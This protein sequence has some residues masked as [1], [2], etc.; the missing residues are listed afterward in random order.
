VTI[1]LGAPVALERY[2][3][4]RDLG[5]FVMIDRLTN[6]TVAVGMVE[7][8]AAASGNVVWHT[9]DVDKH[10][11]AMLKGQRPAAIWF[12]GLSGAGKSTIAN[13]VE[14]KLH[15]LGRHTMMLDGDNVRHGLNRDLGFSE[16]D[17]IENIRRAAEAARLMVDAGLIAL[18]S[19]IS[20][21][22]WDRDSARERFEPG[23]FIEVFVDTPVEECRRRDPKGLYKRADAGQ[24][25]N[26][27][28][29]DAPYEAPLAPEMRLPTVE[30][31]AEELAERVVA[32]LRALGVIGA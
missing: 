24:I 31:S 18:V 11:R 25:R 5:G 12:T 21:Y 26:F 13:L 8:V 16:A 6:A 2:A 10:A 28:G 32:E 14:H 17:R 1:D 29:V 30:A 27:T 3:D 7:T 23:E 22:R 20:P 15:A 9:T 19:F 4:G